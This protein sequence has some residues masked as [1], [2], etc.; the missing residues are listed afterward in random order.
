MLSF[1]NLEKLLYTLSP[2][3]NEKFR[4]LGATV[5]IIRYTALLWNLSITRAAAGELKNF[6]AMDYVFTLVLYVLTS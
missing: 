6:A 4:L 1:Q 5:I 2:K 3:T